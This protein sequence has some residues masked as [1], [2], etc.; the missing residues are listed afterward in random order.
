MP[1]WMRKAPETSWIFRPSVLL[2][3]SCP[4]L[5]GFAPSAPGLHTESA[6]PGLSR[7]LCQRPAW[8]KAR[9]ETDA[10]RYGLPERFRANCAFGGD[11]I[12]WWWAAL[13]RDEH[14]SGVKHTAKS[15]VPTSGGV[16][17]FHTRDSW[18]S[19]SLRVLLAQEVGV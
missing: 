9:Q 14:D 17:V 2:P 18:I 15:G 10:S 1:V 4:A 3:E 8:P 12:P 13:S 7:V 16:P 6:A 5:C 11:P 19:K